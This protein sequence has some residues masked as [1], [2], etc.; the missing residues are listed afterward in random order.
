MTGLILKDFLILRKTLRT[1]LLF[2]IVYVGLAFSGIWSPGFVGGFVMVMVAVLPM[3]VFAYDKQAKWDTYG[4]ALPV[5]RTKTVA[6]RYLC[7]LLLCLSTVVLEFVIGA[8]LFAA[9]KLED[10]GEYLFTGAIF[11]LFAVLLN[12]VML[13]FLYKFGPDRARI[14]LIGVMGIVAAAV[15]ALLIIVTRDDGLAWLES[16]DEPT[17]AQIAAIPV[18]AALAGLV[19]LAVSFLLSRHFYGQK[20]V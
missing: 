14:I 9:G 18:I 2:L 11:G 12:A 15:A 5:G 13:P 19:L 4:L 8:V 17:P 3:N 16:L 10:F 7:V 6:A 20:D 1:Y